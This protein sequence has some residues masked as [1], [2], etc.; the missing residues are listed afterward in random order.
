MSRHD[1]AC[2]FEWA[3]FNLPPELRPGPVILSPFARRAVVFSAASTNAAA[4][5]PFGA[6][7]RTSSG[8]GALLIPGLGLRPVPKP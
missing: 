7:S 6:P 3:E 5:W 2:P 1:D 8:L 4:E